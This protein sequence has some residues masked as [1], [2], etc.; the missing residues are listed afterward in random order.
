MMKTKTMAKKRNKK[1]QD[2]A[3]DI[4]EN[5]EP[6]IDCDVCDKRRFCGQALSGSHCSQFLNTPEP[7]INNG[8]KEWRIIK[9][10][11]K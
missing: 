8:R 4:P 5:L 7:E 10:G 9:E 2:L 11:S 3:T 6:D 1:K